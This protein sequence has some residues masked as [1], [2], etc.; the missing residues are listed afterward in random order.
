MERPHENGKARKVQKQAEPMPSLHP[1]ELGLRA[2]HL[3]V[4][5]PERSVSVTSPSVADQAHET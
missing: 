3:R 2:P 4:K 1:S 5:N